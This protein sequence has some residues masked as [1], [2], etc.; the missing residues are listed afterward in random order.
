[1]NQIPPKLQ[2]L[3][4]QMPDADNVKL[5]Q[6]AKHYSMDLDDPGFLPLLLTR[7]GIEALESAKNELV[8][9]AGGTVTFALCQAQKAFDDSAKSKSDDLENLKSAALIKINECASESELAIKTAVQKWSFDVFCD[10]LRESL[11]LHLPEA[12][13]EAKKSADENAKTLDKETEKFALSVARAVEK[14]DDET[15]NTGLKWILIAALSAL[16]AGSGVGY[17][18]ATKVAQSERV[19]ADQINQ[20]IIKSCNKK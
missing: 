7:Q 9:E 19:N 3:L 10:V 14:I 20:T 6:I 17:I 12:L 8:R 4:Q 13:A 5:V 15:K 2:Q 18:A 1:M 11:K 16:L